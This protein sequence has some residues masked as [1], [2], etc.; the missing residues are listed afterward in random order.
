MH[1]F[2]SAGEPSGD[3]HGQ[4]LIKAI[5]RLDPEARFTGFGGDL[6]QAA[7]CKLLFPLCNLSV[8]F[9][10]RVILNIFTFMR[11]KR[12]AAE[13]FRTE[14][15]DAVVVID[16]PGFH[17]HVAKAAKRAGLPVF[18]FVPPQLWAWA[19][20][21]VGKMRE[22]TD[23]VLSA[24]PF[25]HEWYHARGVN[26]QFIGHPFYDDL[27]AKVL[28]R[29]FL[30]NQNAKPG[31]VIALLPGSR[32]Q[33]VTKNFADIVDAA[34]RIYRAHPETRFLVA[35]FNPAQAEVARQTIYG[36]DLPV[37]IHVGKVSEI[38]EVAESCL[39][40]SGSVCLEVMYR[41]KPAVV[42]YRLNRFSLFVGRK[43]MQVRYITLV[44]LLAKEM[45]YPEYLS[46][47]NP[48]IEMSNHINEW[49]TQHSARRKIVDQLEQL[50]SEIAQTGACQRAAKCI[51]EWVAEA[52]NSNVK[53]AA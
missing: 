45:I 7:G 33:E 9:F 38:I 4:N 11:L 21:R 39:M 37:E 42:I 15:P 26:S 41:L 22:R 2:I 40:V 51:Y 17:W 28:D 10:L 29:Q 49:L 20:W 46:A 48:A 31:R 8:M 16:Y 5:R 19:G 12:Q 32:M 14:K 44:N 27:Q 34:C 53:K 25:E 50:K 30:E 52:E 35:S 24:L 1:Y 47:Q 23:C 13:F 6:M 43:L 36:R 18:Y 3:I